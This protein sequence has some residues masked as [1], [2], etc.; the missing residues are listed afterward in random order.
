MQRQAESGKG[1][2]AGSR[3]ELHLNREINGW[4]ISLLSFSVNTTLQKK[5][6]GGTSMC[7]WSEGEGYPADKTWFLMG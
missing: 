2:R 1:D 3:D 7:H 5:S 4:I 6:A